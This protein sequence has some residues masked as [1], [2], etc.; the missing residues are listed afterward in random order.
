M[1]KSFNSQMAEGPSTLPRK[2]LISSAKREPQ[3]SSPESPSATSGPPPRQIPG[4]LI[5]I[6]GSDRTVF[7]LRQLRMKAVGDRIVSDAQV[8][9]L[10]PKSVDDY[11]GSIFAYRPRSKGAQD[12]EAL[13]D[14]TLFILNNT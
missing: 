6:P 13:K 14:E 11:G 1:T 8:R 3:R 10:S 12:I 7:N 5:L 2:Q 4:K 9:E